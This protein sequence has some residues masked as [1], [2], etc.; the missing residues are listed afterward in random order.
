MRSQA[1]VSRRTL[2]ASAL[3]AAPALRTLP[4]LAQ[5]TPGATPSGETRIV[6]DVYGD[7]SVPVHPKRVIALDGPQLDACLAVGVTPIGAVTGFDGVAF[8]AY[9]G[10]R[11]QGIE[12]I[13]TISEPDLEKI[14]SLEPDLILGSN[15]R[16]EDI[17]PLLAQIAPTVFSEAVSD[18]WR[19]NFA[20]FT[21]ALNESAAAADVVAEF[22]ARLE[23]FRSATEG[24]RQDWVISIVRFLADHVR[25]YN[26]TSF[27]GTILKAADLKRPESQTGADPETGIFSRVS[28]EQIFL[29]DGTHIFTCSYGDVKSTQAADYVNSALWQSL[30]AV[31]EERVYWVDDDFWMVAI[32]FLAANRVVDDLFSYLVEGEPA[33]GIP[34]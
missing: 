14:I 8:P 29:A 3:M 33:A 22:D 5:S 19:G 12:N 27:I 18:D 32:G 20:L 31:Q 21:D 26:D 2:A 1:R 16:N 23:E 17:H 7:V 34:L 24:Q 9:L 13:G 10:D 4:A 6:T 28:L 25:L 11:T 30:E 15:L